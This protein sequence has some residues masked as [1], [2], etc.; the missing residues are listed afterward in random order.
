MCFFFFFRRVSVSLIAAT[1]LS[2]TTLFTDSISKGGELDEFLLPTDVPKLCLKS[3]MC[4]RRA[5]VFITL[6]QL[7]TD[8]ATDSGGK[9]RRVQ[10]LFG[11][12][13]GYVHADVGL[14]VLKWMRGGFC[15]WFFTGV[16]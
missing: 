3:R 15:F 14:F 8:S 13:L 10:S 7:T 11:D 5:G 2:Q 1:S 16:E 4:K 12:I 6:S 9:V